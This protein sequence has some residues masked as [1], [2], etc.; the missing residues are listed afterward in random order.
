L[1]RDVVPGWDN[2]WEDVFRT[3]NWGKY[4]PEALIRFIARNWYGVDDRSRIRLLD[5]GCGPGAC[6]WFM[7]REG[8]TVSGIDGAKTA[9]ALAQERMASE[10]LPAE[11][12]VGDFQSLPWPNEYFDGVV[13]NASLCHTSWNVAQAAVGEILRVL[14]PGGRLFSSSFTNQTWGFGTGDQVGPLTY[15]NIPE[16]PFAN[17]GL[18]RF[19]DREHVQILYCGFEDRTIE[20]SVYT[21]EQMQHRIENWVFTGRKPIAK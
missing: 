13:D 18:V 9:I 8:F 10:N 4:P 16:G 1:S 20:M 14:R 11:F 15:T 12:R 2:H 7:A 17:K 3:Q 19:M 5:L 6:T 21:L